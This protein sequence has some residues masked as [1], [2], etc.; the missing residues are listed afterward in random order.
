MTIELGQK[1]RVLA[2]VRKSQPDRL[3]V[4]C[5]RIDDLPFWLENF[6]VSTE[7]E[8][9]ALWGLDCQK[10]SYSKIF[11]IPPDKTIW[12][13][14]NNWDA[15][16]SSMKKSPLAGVENVAEVEAHNW[17]DVSFVNFDE[18]KRELSLLN[19]SHARIGTI[20]FQ[21]LFCGLCDIFGMEGAM[22]NM[23]TEPTLIEAA[24]EQMRRF[25]YDT[26]KRILD[27]NA[28][29]MDFFWM[30]DDFS[31]QRG[32]MISP[33]LWRKF[34]KPVYLELFEL[35]KSYGVM[36]WFHSC[37]TFAPVIG[38]L[39]DGGMDVWE[40]VQAHLP[41]NE[42][43]QIKQ[44]YGSALSFFGA[45]NCQQTLP[46]GTTEDVRREVRDRFRVL[47]KGGGYIAGPDHSL[48]G[49]IPWRNVEALFDEARKCVY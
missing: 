48:Q 7:K 37:G 24:I 35:V 40:T 44:K 22:V 39:V 4:F 36:V 23:Q 13:C 2:A 31:T 5:G 42:P 46:F 15:G 47:G 27:E 1:E 9:R 25:L 41:G 10:M 30:G 17:P 19:K 11:N 29:E 43:E 6:G 34:C 26:M 16:F 38:E 20:G 8:L 28:S 21:A 18:V 3:P 45:I 14:E 32:M 33:D 12:G 49:N